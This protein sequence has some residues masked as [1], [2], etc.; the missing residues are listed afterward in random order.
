MEKIKIAII[1]N[2]IVKNVVVGDSSFADSLEALTVDITNLPEVEKGWVYENENFVDPFTKLSL[3]EQNEIKSN[4]ERKWRDREL[5]NSDWIVPLTDHP[6]HAAYLVY[7]E[8][9]RNYPQQADF[10]NIER[11]TS[12]L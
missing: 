2:N 7:R 11:P 1:E 10:P 6:Q 5:K 3:E 4:Q 9:L 12:P 8:E